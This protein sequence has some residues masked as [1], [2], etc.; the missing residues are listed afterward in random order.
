MRRPRIEAFDLNLLRILDALDRHR[1]VNLAAGEIGVSPSAVSHAL[2]RLRQNFEDELFVK[3]RDGMAPTTLMSELAKPIGEAL[4]ELRKVLGPQEFDP[5]TSDRQFRLH[6]NTYAASLFMPE[7]VHR[8]RLEAP[9]VRLIIDCDYSRNVADELDASLI[10]LVLDTFHTLPQ[11]FESELLLIDH[12]RWFMRADHPIVTINPTTAKLMA[13]PM[14]V[15]AT[16]NR[17]DT[18]T[19]TF[20]ESGVERLMVPH[21]LFLDDPGAESRHNQ[22]RGTVVVN[23]AEFIP[24]LLARSD[25]ISLLPERMVAAKHTSAALVTL[26]FLEEGDVFEHR[27]VWHRR[28]GADPALD[29]LRSIILEIAAELK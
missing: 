25:L 23:S 14:I 15:I 6:S 28:T 9:S 20:A 27:L 4:R 17:S 22:V 21:P 8:L 13:Q 24:E 10:D 29:W 3:G 16:T 7:L 2:G 26:P 11:R 19:G 5:A 12:W 1:S 18:N